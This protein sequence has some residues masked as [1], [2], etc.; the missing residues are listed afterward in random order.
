M[1]VEKIRLTSETL[2]FPDTV[3]PGLANVSLEVSLYK[4]EQQVFKF[5]T[6][7]GDRLLL[8]GETLIVPIPEGIVA[9]KASII[10]SPA[11]NIKPPVYYKE[12]VVRIIIFAVGDPLGAYGISQFVKWTAKYGEPLLGGQWYSAIINLPKSPNEPVTPVAT[13][14]TLTV[15]WQNPTPIALTNLVLKAQ[16]GNFSNE[17]NVPSLGPRATVDSKHTFF[18]FSGIYHVV[19]SATLGGQAIV[20]KILQDVS[21]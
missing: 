8:V 15:R 14:H 1:R 18:L 21:V 4:L 13:S 12:T 9:D 17:N 20:S 7:Q 19:A 2:P 10:F 6:L 16:I 5:S 3:L 11:E